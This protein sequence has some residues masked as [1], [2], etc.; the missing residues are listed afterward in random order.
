MIFRYKNIFLGLVYFSK[1]IF[2]VRNTQVTTIMPKNGYK[3]GF[4]PTK[5]VHIWIF[6]QSV[7]IK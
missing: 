7:V 4:F 2:I 6:V 3:Q 1:I 5:N